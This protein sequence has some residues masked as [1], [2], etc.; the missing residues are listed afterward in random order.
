VAVSF[1]GGGNWNIRGETTDMPQL[2]EL[3]SGFGLVYSVKRHI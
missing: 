3:V 2:Y 1:I